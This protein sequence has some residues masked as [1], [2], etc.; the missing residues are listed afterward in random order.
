ME[1]RR[2]TILDVAVHPLSPWQS[3]DLLPFFRS[4][5]VKIDG[6]SRP[7]FVCFIAISINTF[8]AY[9]CLLCI[10]TQFA[11]FQVTL[12]IVTS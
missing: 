12:A 9:T 3:H 7:T 8:V 10:S 1:G 2:H 6:V 11:P 4:K 5:I